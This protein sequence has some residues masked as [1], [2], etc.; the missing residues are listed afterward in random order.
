LIV[1]N[2]PVPMVDASLPATIL[3]ALRQAEPE[4][5]SSSTSRTI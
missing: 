1:A 5:D 4:H 2:E 3:G